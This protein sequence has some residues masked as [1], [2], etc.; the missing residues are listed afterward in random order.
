MSLVKT[1]DPMDGVRAFHM[2]FFSLYHSQKD[3]RLTVFLTESKRVFHVL[4]LSVLRSG[5]ATRLAIFLTDR[6]QRTAPVTRA[7]LLFWSL[8]AHTYIR[9]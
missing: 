5:T 4:I 9:H 6:L 8:C 7:T 1:Y 3:S 2:L